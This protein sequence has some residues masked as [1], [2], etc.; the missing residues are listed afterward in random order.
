MRMQ[1]IA[2]QFRTG[3]LAMKWDSFQPEEKGMPMD[4]RD[5]PKGDQRILEDEPCEAAGSQWRAAAGESA[6]QGAVGA[7]AIVDMDIEG[8]GGDPELEVKL[9][10]EIGKWGDV[11]VFWR[12]EAEAVGGAGLREEIELFLAEG[13]A[14]LGYG[15][16]WGASGIKAK[17]E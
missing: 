2:L 4:E 14:D 11:E 6:K 16:G 17:V 7:Q 8:L 1:H 15:A 9:Q 5:N 12:D 10:V 3:F 13:I